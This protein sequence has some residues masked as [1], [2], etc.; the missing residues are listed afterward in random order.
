M[1]RE[2]IKELMEILK[3]SSA[4]EISC[5][6]GDSFIR[7]RRESGEGQVEAETAAGPVSQEAMAQ[8]ELSG[9]EV[10]TVSVKARLVGTF[11]LNRED[12]EQPAVE[13][14][15]QVAEG[16]VIGTVEALGKWTDVVSPVG[17]RVMEIVAEDNSPV[18]YGDVLVRVGP[19]QGGRADE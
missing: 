14:G 19:L 11:H 6:D 3:Q 16:Q 2:R 18:Q 9:D 1:D 7:I 4:A 12:E 15:A 17:G 8:T 5:Q 10:E 13:C